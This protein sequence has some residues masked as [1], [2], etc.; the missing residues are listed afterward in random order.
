MC[1]DDVTSSRVRLV[2]ACA[3]AGI[4]V[5][6]SWRVLKPAAF[7]AASVVPEGEGEPASAV[8]PLPQRLADSVEPDQ[9]KRHIDDVIRRLEP[10]IAAFASDA[11][12]SSLQ[13][14]A[15]R[16][17]LGEML[18]IYLG[19]S[20]A[21]YRRHL[22]RAS[23]ESSFL[24]FAG[25]ERDEQEENWRVAG[26]GIANRP[27]FLR[28]TMFR[29]RFIHGREITQLNLGPRLIRRPP[30]DRY[31][32]TELGGYEPTRSGLT[33]VEI[34][35]PVHYRWPLEKPTA[36]GPVWFGVWLVSDP[37]SPQWLPWCV[38]IYDCA[39]IGPDVAP[40]I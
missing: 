25:E 8:F 16:T 34:V 38:V 33:I 32:V 13:L 4:G 18:E 15:L 27:M 2:A 14:N 21:N 39:G 37:K 7:D 10:D 17:S 6:M 30:A 20:L 1:G 5:A 23:P 36:E 28:E 29:P 12:L 22:E 3:I 35:L 11:R 24:Q 9:L 19:G 26:E 40:M 31:Q